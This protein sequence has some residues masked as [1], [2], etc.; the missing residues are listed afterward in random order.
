M[1]RL[2]QLFF[3]LF[4]VAYSLQ[5]AQHFELPKIAFFL[6]AGCGVVAFVRA[7]EVLAEG[8][9]TMDIFKRIPWFFI[10]VV[11]Y[12]LYLAANTFFALTP[13]LSFWGSYE[14]HQGLFLILGIVFMSFL[15]LT[16]IWKKNEILS[17][18]YGIIGGGV[19]VSLTALWQFISAYPF[20]G[21][22]ST[23]GRIYGAAGHPNFLG[24]FLVVCL[25]LHIFFIFREQNSARWKKVLLRISFFIQIL[26]LLATEN[27][28]SIAAFLLALLF[29]GFYSYRVML[30]QEVKQRLKPYLAKALLL[31]SGIILF[32]ISFKV[33][34]GAF[35]RSILTRAYLLPYV[36]EM[37]SKSP[38]TGY[39][40][41]SFSYAFSPFFP[42]GM[43]ETENFTNM[44]DRA[45]NS[46][47]DLV[48]EQGVIGLIFA[49]VCIM[50]IIRY[51]KE[52]FMRTEKASTEDRLLVCTLVISLIALEVSYFA[53][54]FTTVTK[55][56]SGVIFS[57]ILIVTFVG[58][59]AAVKNKISIFSTAVIVAIAGS[60]FAVAGYRIYT[61]DILYAEA[62]QEQNIGKL[63]QS[64]DM[65]PYRY[66]YLVFG[67]DELNEPE[68]K[69]NFVQKAEAINGHDY[70]VYMQKGRAYAL[71]K[72]N[73]RALESFKK[74][75]TLCPNCPLIPL[76]A[77]EAVARLGNIAEAKKYFDKYISFTPSFYKKVYLDKL[78]RTSLTPYE[79]ERLRIFLKENEA[80]LNFVMGMK[81]EV[82]K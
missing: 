66:E 80:Y 81:G 56:T 54:F 1:A 55:V 45:H 24:Q 41:D 77:G 23:L 13:E 10:T 19:L 50:M 42:Q 17:V 72:D 59:S 11:L 76:Y 27:R 35:T 61:G 78:P 40:F 44:P 14:R 4:P 15:M 70:F 71:L 7:N 30:S 58:K 3:I 49:V 33:F 82:S 38:W 6:V 29:F 68:D 36:I 25:L 22:A 34:D 52:Y 39:G 46:L 53:G 62:R 47:L 9:M 60:I 63:I 65:S 73:E 37:I 31:L 20:G 21:I 12:L 74:A 26:A 51:V 28:A 57:F 67:S 32:Y 16:R 69:L 79:Q 64:I 5:T 48:T 18:L 43:G 2:L 75:E 8:N